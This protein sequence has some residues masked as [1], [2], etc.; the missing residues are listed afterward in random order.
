MNGE[1]T[2][3]AECPRCGGESGEGAFFCARCGESLLEKPREAWYLKTSILII[4]FLAVG[5]F[6]IPLVW[7]NPRYSTTT[8][9]VVTAVM[10]A[11]TGLFLWLSF[12]SL[13]QISA[14]YDLIAEPWPGAGMAK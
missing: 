4:A 8:K 3:A 2:D 1:R 5:P 9:A 6:A 13:Q 12:Y 14:M 10:V 7:V 11:I